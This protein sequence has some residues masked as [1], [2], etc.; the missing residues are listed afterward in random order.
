MAGLEDKIKQLSLA[1]RH[2][3][4]IA[5][6]RQQLSN[7]PGNAHFQFTLARVLAE[8]GEKGEALFHADKAAALNPASSLY[9]HYAGWLYHA[10]NLHEFA[11]P[12]LK[13]A[14]SLEP[15]NPQSICALAKCYETIGQSEKASSLFRTALRFEKDPDKRDN[16]NMAVAR[17]LTT[18]NHRDEAS[19]IYQD[20]LNSGTKFSS[21]AILELGFLTREKPDSKLGKDML[22]MV[23][24]AAP[25]SAEK[26]R[27]LLSLGRIYNNDK[28][29]DRA[30]GCWKASRDIAKAGNKVTR[31]HDAAYERAKS[32]YQLEAFRETA[33]FANQTDC[34]VVVCGMPRSGTTLTE[35]I[36]SSHSK[37]AGAGEI[38]RWGSLDT[39]FMSRHEAGGS[40]K[41]LLAAA[42]AGELRER[43]DELLQILQLVSDSKA[44]RI[45]EKTPHSFYSLGYIK[46]CC[47]RSRFIHLR[48][49]PLDTFISTYQNEFGRWHGY[50]F[51]QVDYAKEF[52]WKE[53]MMELWQG[54]FPESILTVN[55]EELARDPGTVA[56]RMLEFIG[57]EWEEQCLE[58]YKGNRSVRT[59]STAQVRN[60]VYDSSIGRWKDYEKHLGPIM[61]YFHE[62]GFSHENY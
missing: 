1:K 35:Q 12:L 30:F 44:S 42:R 3:E 19:A 21:R 54:L 46:L 28:Q 11:L 24:R 52:L 51:D 17:S 14:V 55:Y 10:F 33:E 31:D 23:A 60:P 58:F 53:R 20:L 36:L 25:G 5:L 16:I 27:A 57:L 47:P 32:F 7:Y 22:R 26:E 59:F 15:E 18:S 45:I 38:A 6:A 8:A 13:R 62:Q 41:N 56:R 49:H 61:S 29:Y 39:E 9:A 43:G 48:R 4:A 34:I 50:V 2:A 37:A 40:L